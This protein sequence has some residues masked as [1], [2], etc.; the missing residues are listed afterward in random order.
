MGTDALA[1]LLALGGA[2][3]SW[4]PALLPWLPQ[5]R[6]DPEGALA[7]VGTG[8]RLC[9]SRQSRLRAHEAKTHRTDL[10][11]TQLVVGEPTFDDASNMFECVVP[12]FSAYACARR[13]CG[14]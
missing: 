1:R 11:L 6:P 8:T 3:F 14:A 5:A 2:F 10:S 4:W 13:F 12:G 7:A 9:F